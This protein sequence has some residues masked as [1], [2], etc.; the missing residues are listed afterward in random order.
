[1]GADRVS[2]FCHFNNVAVAARH[3]QQAHG[4]KRVAII[5]WDVH[6]GNGTSDLFAEDTDVLFFSMHRFDSSGFFPGSGF[7]EDA[8]KG[9]ARGYT[10]NMPLE[11]GF[12]NADAAYYIW[13]SML[14]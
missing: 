4:I 3:A 13:T 12:G 11:K 2:G 5:D 8:G 14:D 10:V 6:H 9:D 1:M 7:L